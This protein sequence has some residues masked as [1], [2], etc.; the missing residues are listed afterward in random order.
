MQ[1]PVGAGCQLGLRSDKP[2]VLKCSLAKVN[3]GFDGRGRHSGRGT[4]GL[5]F[6]IF[7]KAPVRWQR[8]FL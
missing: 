5:C 3:R 2:K 1:L 4:E 8:V 6:I 7:F